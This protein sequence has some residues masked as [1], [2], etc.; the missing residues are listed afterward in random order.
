MGGI[1]WVGAALGGSVLIHC[2]VTKLS[3]FNLRL[4]V[5][6][7]SDHDGFNRSR[8]DSYSKLGVVAVWFQTAPLEAFVIYQKMVVGTV[9]W[10]VGCPGRFPVAASG[11]TVP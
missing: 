1:A 11:A 8:L 10:L 7:M 5:P 4:T 6:F 9:S 2:N 3:S